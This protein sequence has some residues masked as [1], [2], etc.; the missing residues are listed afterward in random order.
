MYV[1]GGETFGQRQKLVDYTFEAMWAGIRA[2]KPGATLG[3]VGAAIQKVADQGRFSVVTDFAGH[4]VGQ[5]FHE[6]P[7]V[8]H[9]GKPG[10]GGGAAPWHDLSPLSL[11]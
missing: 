5:K 10:R 1:V 11:C 7:T 2:V 4:G 9:T 3:D 6:P 8:V